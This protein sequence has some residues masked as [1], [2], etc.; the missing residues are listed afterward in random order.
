MKRIIVN[1]TLILVLVLSFSASA[2]AQGEQ[3]EKTLPESLDEFK[4]DTPV[5]V[6]GVAPVSKL[7]KGLL[8][9]T[10]KQQV[11]IRLKTNPVARIAASGKGIS[12]QK[13]QC[14]NA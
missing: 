8:S 13:N 5:T 10:G 4:L 1:L 14:G 9:A 3:P 2:L 6:E 7:D 11:V 12:D